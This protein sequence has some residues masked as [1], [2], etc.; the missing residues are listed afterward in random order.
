MEI[1]CMIFDWRKIGTEISGDKTL[2][3]GFGNTEDGESLAIRIH[4]FYNY[5]YVE[6]ENLTI[7]GSN[8]YDSIKKINSILK[9]NRM[10]K[11]A[12][13]TKKFLRKFLEGNKVF[14]QCF[15]NNSNAL[16][17]FCNLMKKNHIQVHEESISIEEKFLCS[18]DISNTGWIRCTCSEVPQEMKLSTLKKE[19]FS[20]HDKIR[21]FVKNYIP[22]PLIVS[23]D[24]EVYSSNEKSMPDSSLS[25]DKIFMIS[26][27]SQR[28]LD[29][30]TMKKYLLYVSECDVIINNA[31]CIRFDNE[32]E[33]I[34]GYLD[35]V[36]KLD[37]DVIIGYNIFAFDFRYMDTRMQ[38]RLYEIKN[39][40][41]I[42]NG[43]TERIEINW[44]SSAYGFNDYLILDSL[45][46]CP[47]DVFQYIKKE[48]KLQQ[49]GLSFVSENFLGDKKL[50]MSPK[51]MFKLYRKG[52]SVSMAI[53][54]EYCIKDSVLTMNLFDKMNIWV[55]FTEMSNIMRT[56]IRDLYTRGQQIRVR[57]QLYKECHDSNMVMDKIENMK[58]TFDYEG[59]IVI[60]PI[61]GIYKWCIALD[62]SSLY[63]SII[64]SHNMCY[65]TFIH[66]K[67]D[68]MI[69]DEQCHIVIINNKKYRFAKNPKGVVPN[70]LEKL[71]SNRKET[72]NSIKKEKDDLAKIILDRRQWAYKISANSVYGS[73]GAKNS[74]YL[75]FVEGAECTTAVGR[76]FITEASYLIE[77]N[78]FVKNIYGDTDSC[79]IRCP[80]LKD[81]ESC[82]KLGLKISK[83]VSL[84]FPEPVKLEFEDV[85]EVFLLITK[86]RYTAM[87][88]NTGKKIYKGVVVSRRDSCTLVRDIY[89]E[90]LHMIMTD[91][92]KEEIKEYL[93]NV[94]LNVVQGNVDIKNLVIRRTLNKNYS[95]SA[96][97]QLIYSKRLEEMGIQT[98]PGDRL[99]FVFV[100]SNHKLQGHKMYPP[101]MVLSEGLNI[102]YV[103]YIENHIMN[104]IDQLLKLAGIEPFVELFAEAYKVL[105][106]NGITI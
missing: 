31:K 5:V 4:D 42:I 25:S 67:Y 8:P 88:A 102:D 79:I 96:N 83:E 100:K 26:V 45:G 94:L 92:P 16:N 40:S 20:S 97:P 6:I 1:E 10:A 34:D 28:Y 27:I 50:D 105:D 106:A 18:L 65:S 7:F 54:G 75:Q 91:K 17:H 101:E 11:Y 103:Y 74:Q 29:P 61:P 72:K 3:M 9:R 59:A 23:M 80:I 77:K 64:I 86:K 82:K 98:V 49:Y 69:H 58:E 73:Y 81:Y 51:N 35:I 22:K 71:I 47:I 60:N 76:K 52:D 24:I 33:L 15:F 53:I 41:R 68:Y 55:C 19:Y 70:L 32:K 85:F 95:S 93:K 89:S 38:R 63:P 78:Y 87:S 2:I 12:I 56:K 30:S 62:F 84:H 37:P 13:V 57:A 36:V 104:P 99:E 43:K 46:R 66:S 21:G 90:I 14:V 44:Q 39:T 48:H